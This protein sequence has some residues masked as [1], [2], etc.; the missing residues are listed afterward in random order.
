MFL[1]VRRHSNL[2]GI[3]RNG[4]RRFITFIYIHDMT[5]IS[6]KYEQRPKKFDARFYT[7]IININ[8]KYYIN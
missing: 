4:N 6:V 5:C 1:E 8:Y 2:S 7:N 3:K